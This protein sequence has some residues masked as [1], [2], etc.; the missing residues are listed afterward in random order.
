M[1]ITIANPLTKPYI[2]GCGTNRMNFPSFNNPTI[3]WMIPA[4]AMAPK[5]YSIPCD[6]IKAIK[7]ITVAPAPPDIN[8]GRPPK[9]P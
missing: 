5:T 4:K 6:F 3:I 1:K 2:T 7:T 9:L 8:P